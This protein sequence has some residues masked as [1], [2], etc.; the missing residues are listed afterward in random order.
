MNNSKHLMKNIIFTS[1]FLVSPLLA[2]WQPI[3][4]EDITLTGIAPAVRADTSRKAD[5]RVVD[6]DTLAAKVYIQHSGYYRVFPQ[7]WLDSGNEQRNESYFLTIHK[8]GEVY[9]P[10]DPNAGQYRVVP[11]DTVKYT[12]F[13]LYFETDAGLW[14]LEE[15]MNEIWLHHY[16]K[17]A[18]D[19]PEFINYY[20]DGRGIHGSESIYIWEYII[21]KPEPKVDGAVQLVFTDLDTCIQNGITRP[22]IA[23][24][25]TLLFD[26]VAQNMQTGF[27]RNGLPSA[28]M[29]LNI[30][31]HFQ[32]IDYSLTPDEAGIPGS[33]PYRWEITQLRDST[34]SHFPI[35]IQA[36]ALQEIENLTTLDFN[37]EFV[38]P[39]DIDN[40]NNSDAATLFPATPA[41]C[42]T[43]IAVELFSTDVDRYVMPGDTI[44][45]RTVVK[46]L[47]DNPGFNVDLNIS[48]DSK[49][50]IISLPAGMSFLDA[51]TLTTFY[52]E[53]AVGMADTLSML[54]RVNNNA[55]LDATIYNL[56]EIQTDFDTNPAN[57]NDDDQLTIGFPG[58]ADIKVEQVIQTDSVRNNGGSLENWASM[59]STLKIQLSVTNQ[60]AVDA[61]NVT[62][63]DTLPQGI[64]AQGFSS[65]QLSWSFTKLAPGAVETVELICSFTDTTFADGTEL[66]NVAAV[67]CQNE[68]VSNLGDNYSEASLFTYKYIPPVEYA[69]LALELEVFG[70]SSVIAGNDTLA[71]GFIDQAFTYRLTVRNNGPFA[72]KDF[73]VA[74]AIPSGLQNMVF[75]IQPTFQPA[76]SA[77]WLISMLDIGESWQVEWNST[78]EQPVTLPKLI[79]STAKVSFELDTNNANNSDTA[80]YM[81]MK[82]PEKFIDLAVQQTAQTDSVLLSGQTPLNFVHDNEEFS[83][84]II[85]KNI[86]DLDADNL[87]LV[88]SL[89]TDLIYKSSVPQAQVA[90]NQLYW[91]IADLAVHDSMIVTVNCQVP[92]QSFAENYPFVNTVHV[93]AAGEP[94]SLTK[95]NRSELA[96][97]FY[98]KRLPFSDLAVRQVVTTDSLLA[99]QAWTTADEPFT[100]DIYVKNNGNATAQSVTLMDTLANELTV[101]ST[102]PPAQINNN[103][104]QWS[105]NDLAVGDSTRVQVECVVSN[106]DLAPGQTLSSRVMAR[107]ANEP[108][109][110][111][112]DNFSEKMVYFY[113]PPVRVPDL[114]VTQKAF[115]DSSLTAG[116]VH[117]DF[118]TQ[119]EMFTLQ[120]RVKN[121]GNAQAFNVQLNNLLPQGITLIS[122]QPQGVFQNDQWQWNLSDLNAEDS[123]VVTLTCQV[124]DQIFADNHSFINLAQVSA[125]NE[126][127]SLLADNTS[128]HQL[129]FYETKVTNFNVSIRQQAQTD[130]L[131]QSGDTALHFVKKNEIFMLNLWVKNVGTPADSVV[132]HNTLPDGVQLVQA[133][134]EA[135]NE[136]GRLVWQ[137]GSMANGDSTLMQLICQVDNSDFAPNHPFVNT[138]A[139]AAK[140]EPEDMLADNQSSLAVFYYAPQEKY[141]D[142]QLT[143]TAHTD[144]IKSA[145]HF[146]TND[147]IFFY[148]LQLENIGQAVAQNVVVSDTLPLGINLV[149]SDPTA[150]VSENILTW[151]IGNMAVNATAVLS[152]QCRV[153]TDALPPNTSLINK[154][155]ATALNEPSTLLANNYAELAVS[156]YKIASNFD[157]QV[158]YSVVADSLFD[159]NSK[160]I[161]AIE[162][163]ETAQFIIQVKNNGPIESDQATLRNIL[164]TEI[165]VDNTSPA[166]A[167]MDGQFIWQLPV[168][169]V[170]EVWQVTYTGSFSGDGP[171]PKVLGATAVVQ[172]DQDTN[173]VNNSAAVDL[174]VYEKNETK[175]QCDVWITQTAQT[176]SVVVSGSDSTFY[177]NSKNTFAYVLK[178]GNQSAFAAEQ[179]VLA[180]DLPD[181][182]DFVS[183]QPAPSRI[184]ADSCFWEFATLE[185]NVKLLLYMQAH[186]DLPIGKNYLLNSATISAENEDPGKLNNNQS[187]F[188]VINFIP[189]P[190]PLIVEIIV[191]PEKI[192]VT[193]SA[194]VQVRF[195]QP[196]KTWDIVITLPDGQ[197]I[198]DFAD[199]FIDNTQIQPNRWYTI[200]QHYV[201]PHLT[202]GN[203]IDELIF[204]AEAT[205]IYDYFAVGQDDLTVISS[206]DMVLDLNVFR[207]GLDDQVNISFKLSGGADCELAVF[208]LAGHKICDIDNS[209]Y[210]GGWNSYAWNART[211]DGSYVG[212]GTYLITLHHVYGSFYKKMIIVR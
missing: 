165:A 92:D 34:V 208:D 193:D 180:C 79:S 157:L 148:R 23:A 85:V 60:S 65:R 207:V 71:A 121:H 73:R 204:I 173:T 5:G 197:T 119:N 145:Q 159:H 90:G 6:Q 179:V 211:Q 12:E 13:D 37:A 80:L 118:V 122:S 101:V 169:G 191:D 113:P 9:Y 62:L 127:D 133:I 24:G 125:T 54:A 89:S 51:N 75:T 33:E 106:P 190:D 141:C 81:L 150:T 49:I 114:A 46:N 192:D 96:V 42:P 40:S 36:I 110:L 158:T 15:G 41:S 135:Q 200:D 142:L 123:L 32:P 43:D 87:I 108:D 7:V 26:V 57:N 61:F 134:P 181:N 194:A 69:D 103:I 4:E 99:D 111:L 146:V 94:D 8:D 130:S 168:L 154:A 10:L 84:Q 198:D 28:T 126:P 58:F 77:V 1:L 203:K 132:V 74:Q 38:V 11:D 167:Q 68:D 195:S 67:T 97:F 170:G 27:F 199:H 144:S 161:P 30:P 21:F 72:A 2:Q 29:L 17:I 201:H 129:L 176:D 196:V 137:V 117:F 174:A 128:Q 50:Q 47:G 55:N 102:N 25:D 19:Y 131:L 175:E 187:D 70:D 151:N 143:Q 147:E 184:S 48:L 109:S 186:D 105:L 177:T 136:A 162:K 120:L 210:E 166:P 139:V 22:V 164:P 188:S 78:H 185:N 39:N 14:Y 35:Q 202:N 149:S 212:S 156:Y 16:A 86:G 3:P 209:F 44:D 64:I 172:A 59:D 107:S 52:S 100:F 76:D 178:I 116:A 155:R 160:L 124:A 138:A 56:A 206:D 45:L 95:D 112:A 104:L 153:Q 98:E 63:V 91:N 88:D 31:P 189:V 82:K 163:S 93:E 182:A 83:Y 66:L 53:V 20:P 152:L 18:D 140:D 171:F 205:S 183:A 115:T